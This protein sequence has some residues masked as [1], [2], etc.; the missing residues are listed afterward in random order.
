MFNNLRFYY[1]LKVFEF[2]RWSFVLVVSLMLAETA[3]GLSLPYLIGQQSQ[4]FLQEVTNLNS[5]HLKYL[6]LWVGLFAAQAVL[7]FLS[8]YNVNLVGARLMADF[9]CRLYD[10]IQVL[11]IQYFQ[12]NKRGD[13]LSMLTN[14]LAV[15]SF[16]VSSVLT[17]LIP[18]VLVLI[19][20]SVLMYLIEPTIALLICFLVPLI[21]VILKVVSRGMQ[22]ISRQLMQRQADTLAQAS[23]NIGAISLIKAFNKEDDESTKFRNRTNEVLALRAK[24]FKLQALLSPLIQF[25]ASLCIMAV[26]IMSVLKFNAGSLSIPDLIT[27]LLYGIVFTR[28]LGSLAGLYGQLQ[29]VIGASA[30]L[31]H[32]YHLESEPRDNGGEA[33]HISQGDIVF[34]NVTFGFAQR[35]TILQDISFHLKPGQNM[36]I[37]GQNG[38]GKT[39]LLH[40]L[41]RFYEPAGGEILIDGYNVKQATTRSLRGA[42]G[43]VSQDVLLL[44]GSIFDNL[45]Y[46]LVNPVADEVYKA[47]SQAGLDSIIMRLPNGYE[48]QV[49]EGGIRLSGGQRQ[50]IA[51]ARAL[52]LEPKILLLDEPTSMLD[53]QGRLSFKEEFHGLF[54]RFT[55]IMISH[56]PTLSD[57]ADVVYKLENGTLQRQQ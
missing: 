1:G 48:T 31:L 54:A 29:Q 38:G 27:L 16:F 14:D 37:Y 20:A 36:L 40:L 4:A 42:I 50:R 9:S 52:L 45:T 6:Y 35:G 49:G 7:R 13:V 32:V 41:M 5:S 39:T 8:S 12:E 55:V 47:A 23:E 19:G 56:D 11:P 22:P 53:D 17:N 15:V 21:Y 46:G 33:V 24:Q 44:N 51:L 10:H 25:L 34:N 2:Y 28:P 26:V 30:R 57:V 18:N 43:L 3:V